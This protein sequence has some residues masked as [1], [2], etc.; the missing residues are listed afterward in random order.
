MPDDGPAPQAT[1]PHLPP[2]PAVATIQRRLALIFP[3]GTP[4]RVN[5]VAERA[6]KTA[7]VMLY[8][9]AI[10]D[11]AL[12]RPDQVTRMSD[13]QAAKTSDKDRS[14]WLVKSMKG[15]DEVAGRWYSVN[16]REG[17][18]DDTLR[19]AWQPLGA[20]VEQDLPTT[21][22]KPRWSLALPF[23]ALLTW[24]VTAPGEPADLQAS[25]QS[26]LYLD[27][28][29]DWQRRHLSA[30]A[31]ARVALLKKVM[32]T[33]GSV[34]VTLPGIGKRQLAPGSSS[35]IV[36]EL[37]ESFVPKFL[38][39]PVVVWLSESSE[40]VPV[41]HEEIARK[42]GLDMSSAGILP[43]VVLAD[44]G[45]SDDDFLLL[46]VEI[47]ASDGPVNEERKTLLLDLATRGNFRPSQVAF[48]TAFADRSAQPFKK[49]ADCVAWNTFSWTASEPDKLTIHHDASGSAAKL[50]S[51]VK[52]LRAS[53]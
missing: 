50:S 10:G 24:G 23:A 18:R 45:E 31:L 7:F 44:L 20:V 15:R 5:A 1:T 6:A 47:V 40:H 33:E 38:T 25:E 30:S 13:E 34:E 19:Y 2:L 52:L 32:G 14:A 36:K 9:G 43:D 27:F 37:I 3:E 39:Q 12:I 46:F 16:S 29:R 22:S 35:V 49:L 26:D 48:L 41:V 17:I 21:S 11:H 53:G 4:N 8:V 42:V 51:L 28:I